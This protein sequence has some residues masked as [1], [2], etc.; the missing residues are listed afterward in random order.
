LLITIFFQ[1]DFAKISSTIPKKLFSSSSPHFLSPPVHPE[2]RGPCENHDTS[3]QFTLNP[4]EFAELEKLAPRISSYFEL[5]AEQQK[6]L[7]EKAEIDARVG[8]MSGVFDEPS[9]IE[10]HF[11]DMHK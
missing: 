3:P 1:K 2:S 4:E 7:A 5:Y 6:R 8:R 9:E 10:E 11:R